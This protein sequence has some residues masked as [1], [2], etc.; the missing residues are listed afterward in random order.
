[1]PYITQ[2]NRE[3]VADFDNESN[4]L[5]IDLSEI[6]CGGDLNYLFTFLAGAY[7]EKHGLRYQNIS[8]VMGAY[9]GSL[10][11]I[12]RLVIDPY[13]EYTEMKNGGI[14]SLQNLNGQAYDLVDEF[15]EGV[16]DDLLRGEVVPFKAVN[17][18]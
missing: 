14:S 18:E 5:C 17:D 7:I 9:S 4:M 1:M 13:E 6:S 8:D 3:R 11:E 15:N 2:E 12:E 16:E 10:R